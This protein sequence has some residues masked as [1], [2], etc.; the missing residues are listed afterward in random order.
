MIVGLSMI[1]APLNVAAFMHIP[2]ELRGA[3]VGLLALLAQRGRQRRHV[4]RADHRRT[5]RAVS[6]A[7]AQRTA[8]SAQ[9]GRHGRLSP[10]PGV[11]PR[12][13]PA[14]LPLSNEMTLQSARQSAQ[15]QALSLAYFDV[16][17]VSAVIGFV[18]IFVRAA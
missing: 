7:A 5:P 17:W 6:H 12:R 13:T 3:A 9:P 14:T 10:R 11:L 8:R 4:G 1:F 15:Q 16:F 18:L 2:R